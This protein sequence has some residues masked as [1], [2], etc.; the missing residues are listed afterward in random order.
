[1]AKKLNTLEKTIYRKLLSHLK[2]E[3]ETIF[4]TSLEFSCPPWEIDAGLEDSPAVRSF[5]D[6]ID[7]NT[8]WK[9]TINKTVMGF[10]VKVQLRNEIGNEGLRE[11]FF[12]NVGYTA[13][14]HT[15]VDLP[16]TL[17]EKFAYEKVLPRIWPYFRQQALDTYFK[18]G[19]I[20][21]LIPLEP[22]AI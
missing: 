8:S 20:E 1:M 2:E 22:N 15:D 3:P 18:A 9:Y 10:C 5:I 17:V 14:Y 16:N 11:T 6:S 13:Y 12:L 7:N 4:L 19:I 21:V